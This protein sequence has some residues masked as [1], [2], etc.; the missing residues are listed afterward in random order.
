M[1]CCVRAAGSSGRPFALALEAQCYNSLGQYEREIEV[2]KRV[3][4]LMPQEKQLL[5]PIWL[6]LCCQKSRDFRSARAVLDE[7]LELVPNDISAIASRAEISLLDGHATEAEG[8]ARKLRERPEPVYQIL[9]RIMLAIALALQNRQ[10]ES[11]NE[12]LW[13]GQFIL[14]GGKIP[15]GFWEY[16]DITPLVDR[17]GPNAYVAGLLLGALS[18][19]VSLPDFTE[20]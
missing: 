2:F 9:G 7:L 20:R 13:I 3:T 12:M 11:R 19:K 17:L 16:R 14:S 15:V 1:I 8:R 10:E 4:Q 6:V 18:N 5:N